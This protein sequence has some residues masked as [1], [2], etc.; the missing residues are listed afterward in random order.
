LANTRLLLS[1]AFDGIAF[2]T[3]FKLMVVLCCC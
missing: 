1:V 2:W 3:I